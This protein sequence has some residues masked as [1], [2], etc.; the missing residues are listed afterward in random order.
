VQTFTY[1]ST[2]TAS[3]LTNLDFTSLDNTYKSY[4]FCFNTLASGGSFQIKASTD[5]LSTFA[6]L[7]MTYEKFAG[8]TPQVISYITSSSTAVTIASLTSY[9]GFMDIANIGEA[10]KQIML[11]WNIS[12]T[13]TA[14]N[15]TATH[16]TG[17]DDTREAINSIRF[18]CTSG[19][20]SAG[21]ITLYGIS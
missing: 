13:S 6:T 17:Q 12:S 5:N 20:F 4:R 21:T 11:S 19:T 1:I 10:T 8:G 7:D 14:T 15:A 3:G 2:V 18:L 16:G 9:A